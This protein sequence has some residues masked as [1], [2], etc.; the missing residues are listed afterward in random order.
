MPLLRLGLLFSCL[1]PSSCD[2]RTHRLHRKN[3]TPRGC[4]Q[5]HGRVQVHQPAFCPPSSP[6]PLSWLLAFRLL[7]W[8]LSR[9]LKLPGSVRQPNFWQMLLAF[10]QETF[11]HFLREISHSKFLPDSATVSR[12]ESPTPCKVLHKEVCRRQ[13]PNPSLDSSVRTRGSQPEPIEEMGVAMS[14]VNV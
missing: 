4:D 7:F 12:S 3:P 9:L 2:Q 10:C 5:F 8:Q 11:L 13:L 1:P 14:L 6:P